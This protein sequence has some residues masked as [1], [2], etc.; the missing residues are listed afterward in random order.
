[1]CYLFKKNNT[2]NRKSSIGYP[3][4]PVCRKAQEGG[5]H[6]LRRRF[7]SGAAQERPP[8]F[9]P[10]K[11]KNPGTESEKV[12]RLWKKGA[13]PQLPQNRGT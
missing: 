7:L 12:P 9:S 4:F 6:C 5:S 1:M 13:K 10:G 3:L 8:H 11:K 2:K